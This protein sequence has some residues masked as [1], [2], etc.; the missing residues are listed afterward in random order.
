MH[1]FRKKL[2]YYLFIVYHIGKIANGIK[3]NNLKI[4]GLDIGA[5]KYCVLILI[6]Y[7]LFFL[8]L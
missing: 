7:R 3:E 5:I 1:N 8:D 4:I 2:V 6:L